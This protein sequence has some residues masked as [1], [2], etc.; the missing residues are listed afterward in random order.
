MRQNK[1]ED[2]RF[3]VYL[4]VHLPQSNRELDATVHALAETVSAAIDCTTCAHCC[5]TL[6]ITVTHDDSERL[7]TRLGLSTE[8]F[9]ERYTTLSGQQT[10]HFTQSPCAF[11]GDDLRCT[12]YED[13]PKV[14]RD[15]PSLSKTHF[16]TRA[17]NVHESLAHCPIVFNVWDLLKRR[18]A[19]AP[20]ER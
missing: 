1:A 3:L 5:Q 9:E 2:A 10:R 20:D 14:C 11:L 13:R 7:A 16:R 19:V 8:A 15:Y 6:Q 4:K 17:W 18:Y 12:V